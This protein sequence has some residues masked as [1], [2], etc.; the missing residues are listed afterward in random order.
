M[1]MPEVPETL[2]SWLVHPNSHLS[3]ANMNWLVLIPYSSLSGT[4]W[5]TFSAVCIYAVRRLKRIKVK[6]RKVIVEF[7]KK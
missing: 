2:I 1:R 4:L 3:E 6:K 7:K 5:F